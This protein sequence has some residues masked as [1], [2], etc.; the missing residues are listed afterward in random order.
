MQI[1]HNNTK[2]G[3]ILL[4]LQETNKNCQVI[5]IKLLIKRDFDRKSTKNKLAEKNN[6][7][8]TQKATQQSRKNKISFKTYENKNV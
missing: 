5:P 6:S 4:I 3:G 1:A 2:R 7:T 8:E